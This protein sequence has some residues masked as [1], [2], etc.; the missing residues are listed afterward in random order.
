MDPNDET[1]QVKELL[2]GGFKF[3]DSPQN[4]KLLHLK[5]VHKW[6]FK[7]R[8]VFRRYSNFYM[9][10]YAT[11]AYIDTSQELQP[12]RLRENKVKKEQYR[13]KAEL[14]SGD[15]EEDPPE[16]EDEDSDKASNANV[17]EGLKTEPESLG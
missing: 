14:V 5:D 3:P 13:A 8:Q 2:S 6:L 16:S 4:N 12:R 10:L 9:M 11:V 7:T 15:E 17:P 1:Y